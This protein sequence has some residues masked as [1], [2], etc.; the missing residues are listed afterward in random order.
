MKQP[1]AS[2]SHQ[3]EGGPY[4][5]EDKAEEAKKKKKKQEPKAQENPKKDQGK[6]MKEEI[7]RNMKRQDLW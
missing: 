1:S 2:T 3:S 5:K 7:R 4:T 6:K